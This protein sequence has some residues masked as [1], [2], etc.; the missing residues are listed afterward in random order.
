MY[1]DR[2][3]RQLILSEAQQTLLTYYMIMT[4]AQLQQAYEYKSNLIKILTDKNAIERHENDLV[5]IG[6]RIELMGQ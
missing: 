3:R 4:I 5:I 6:A 2:S 1:L